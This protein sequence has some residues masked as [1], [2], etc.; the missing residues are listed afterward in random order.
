MCLYPPHADA[1][2]IT[3]PR[4][5]P[6][7]MTVD[8]SCIHLEVVVVL[9]SRNLLGTRLVSCLVALTPC[10]S[11][12]GCLVQDTSASGISSVGYKKILSAV[13]RL[14]SPVQ[15][16]T[17]TPA[18]PGQLATFQNNSQASL[19]RSEMQTRN[20]MQSLGN[21][22]NPSAYF[23]RFDRN[24]L[25]RRNWLS[26]AVNHKSLITPVAQSRRSVLCYKSVWPQ[27]GGSG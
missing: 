21:M 22:S 17:I 1:K 4:Y 8:I 20:E 11:S 12:A 19:N 16:H 2:P 26:S 13:R 10:C 6:R 23:C 25:N 27:R 15:L 3:S 14:G 7:T 5:Y 18:C 9:H 24:L